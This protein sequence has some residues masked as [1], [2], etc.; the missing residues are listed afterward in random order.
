VR[1][2]WGHHHREWRCAGWQPFRR[3]ARGATAPQW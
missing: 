3:N 2:L 1:R